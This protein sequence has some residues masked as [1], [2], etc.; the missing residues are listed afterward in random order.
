[1][2]SPTATLLSPR[3]RCYFVKIWRFLMLETVEIV[4]WP[5]SLSAFEW[6]YSSKALSYLLLGEIATESEAYRFTF[7]FAS[8]LL[9]V[10][11]TKLVKIS[12]YFNY[13]I[14]S[15]CYGE[16]LHRIHREME[17]DYRDQWSHFM[18]RERAVALA[19]SPLTH[20]FVIR[21]A[22]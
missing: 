16:C 12:I 17:Q 11:Y 3:N 21:I 19:F 14:T 7:R 20:I 1:M 18:K 5:V 22:T 4:P 10:T 15:D 13:T 6:K 9:L 8:K 2:H